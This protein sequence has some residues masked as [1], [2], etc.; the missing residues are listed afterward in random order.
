MASDNEGPAEVVWEGADLERGL[1][2]EDPRSDSLG[3]A[4]RWVAVYHHLV[5]LEQELLDVLARLIP[6]M[7]YEARREAAEAN[8]P[9]LAAQVERFRH[10]LAF[11]QERRD[12]LAGRQ[13]PPR[14]GRRDRRSRP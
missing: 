11:W 9:V 14:P 1:A 7:P 4:Q 3:D 2:G 6:N 10:R 13:L 8:L 5:Q 12:E